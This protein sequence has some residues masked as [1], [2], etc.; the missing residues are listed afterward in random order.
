MV[1]ERMTESE[2][3]SFITCP[4][5]TSR[6]AEVGGEPGVRVGLWNETQKVSK[7]TAALARKQSSQPGESPG[8]PLGKL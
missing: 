8:H 4:N 6:E 2:V 3:Q 7:E 5:Q 1:N